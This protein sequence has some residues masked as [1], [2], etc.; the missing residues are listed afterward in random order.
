VGSAA[1][2]YTAAEHLLAESRSVVVGR[3]RLLADVYQGLNSGKG[4]VMTGR[5]GI[6]KT[7]V[8]LAAC[9]QLSD[10]GW[11]VARVLV[12]AGPGSTSTQ[13]VIRLLAEQLERTVPTEPAGRDGEERPLS[14]EALLGWWGS[15]L[16]GLP[17]RTL[18]AVDGLDRLDAGDD[19]DRIDVLRSLAGGARFLASSTLDGQAETLGVRLMTVI[20]VELLEPS[21]AALAVAELASTESRRA[22]P[23]A[24]VR[25]L[26]SV[27]RTG[28]WLRLAV[29]EL[30]WLDRTDFSRAEARAAAG[31]DPGV[32]LVAMLVSEAEDLP[33]DDMDLASR[34]V[35]RA[36]AE[37]NDDTAA[38][39][40]LG[41]LAL[42]RSGLTHADLQALAGDLDDALPVTRA[43]Q[44]LGGQ[45]VARDAS[46]RWAFDHQVVRE[47]A[48]ARAAQSTWDEPRLHARLAEHLGSPSGGAGDDGTLVDTV[49]ALDR[50]SHALLSGSPELTAGALIRAW[51]SP[52][53]LETVGDAVALAVRAGR[54]PRNPALDAIAGMPE[55]TAGR[56]MGCLRQLQG[57][58]QEHG[59][60]DL[61]VV[62][63][64]SLAESSLEIARRLAAEDRESAQARRDVS[65]SLDNVGRV[66]LAGGDLA[67][68][69]AAYTESLEMRRRLAAEDRE[70]AQARR[71]VS[72]SLWRLAELAETQSGSDS[73]D[74]GR[75]WAE[76][77][78]VFDQMRASSMIVPADEQFEQMARRKAGGPGARQTL[79]EL[80]GD[81]G[82]AADIEAVVRFWLDTDTWESSFD[83]LHSGSQML[84][85]QAG[86]DAVVKHSRGHAQV[87]H[88]AIL[89]ALAG[90]LEESLVK[91]IVSDVDSAQHVASQA[92]ANRDH[93]VV[94]LVLA[95]NPELGSSVD[96]AAIFLASVVLSGHA[97]EA[98]RAGQQLAAEVGSAG[99]EFARALRRIAS[100]FPDG[101]LDADGLTAVLAALEDG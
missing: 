39:L 85:T 40:F 86:L 56:H 19:R 71:D 33:S 46:G 75:A 84:V 7:T 96:G 66:A 41:A 76:V 32:A 17:E 79:E 49:A 5:S 67:G 25:V 62:E 11:T 90:G 64:G 8:F 1:T 53:S 44:L 18:V 51:N 47:A 43:R 48:L 42:T 36:A 28:L 13:E 45:L 16:A 70:S 78:E 72:V 37:F 74:A 22:L 4:V 97:E 99:S 31:E 24:V 50:L 87:V 15:V 61:S 81:V 94:E 92:L 59:G 26:A 9:D 80:M 98:Q 100:E 10:Q 91:A 88:V 35:A 60:E 63:W 89:Q 6:G 34:V 14:G 83:V 20:P 29:T 23:A 77:L 95:L 27:P 21:A 73:A 101:F 3:E 68:A 58:A 55:V 65:V 2:G 38:G 57:V 30:V 69:R 54:G 93:R 82:D 52:L 12:G